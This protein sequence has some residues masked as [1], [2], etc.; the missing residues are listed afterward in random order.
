MVFLGLG[1]VCNAVT[2]C[3]SSYT[4][5]DEV[6]GYSRGEAVVELVYG[7]EGK[8]GDQAMKRHGF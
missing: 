4:K 2:V 3:K 7:G 6:T 1:F 8:V 5:I